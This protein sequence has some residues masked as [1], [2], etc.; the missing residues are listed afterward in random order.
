[1]TAVLFTEYLED[2][3]KV[4]CGVF[5]KFSLL[6][7]IL[8]FYQPPVLKVQWLNHVINNPALSFS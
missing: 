1:M 7:A 5:E 2:C 8:L 6:A 3:S 4:L